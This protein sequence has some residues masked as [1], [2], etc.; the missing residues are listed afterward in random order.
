VWLGVGDVQAPSRPFEIVR[1]IKRLSSTVRALAP[2]VAIGFM[3][4][5]YIP[6]ALALS[7]SRIPVVASEHIGYDHFRKRR[8][9][10]LALRATAPLYARMTT[11]SE[12]LKADFPGYL[13]KRMEVL[14][15]PVEPINRRADPIG[16]S[17]KKLL[18]VGRLTEQKD[19]R[20]LIEAFAKIA[21]LH[22][23]W[24]L[25]IVG[26]GGLHSELE[27]MIASLGLGKRVELAGIIE[28]ME[29]EYASAQLFAMSSRYESFGLA[30]AEALSAGI[31]AIGFADCA[32]TNE[33]IR[34]NVNGLLVGG[35]DR[36]V[37]LAQGLNLLMG[38]PQLRER[39]GEAA[40]ASVRKFDLGAIG[41]QWEALLDDVT[42]DAG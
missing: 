10:A 14:P 37:A 3:H 39:M 20:T 7:H 35:G 11:I 26:Q 22:P 34:H 5:A 16:G 2:D 21:P 24:R 36:V 12:A 4:S 23:D 18:N 15:N 19:Q 25:R 9:Q 33:L 32:G 29:S 17:R 42:G 41:A 27:N 30:T 1:R 8:L 6:L 13:A 40:P 28:D 31:P 38:S